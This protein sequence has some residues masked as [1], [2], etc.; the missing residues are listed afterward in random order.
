MGDELDEFL[1]CVQILPT[2]AADDIR[3][4]F[5]KYF[6][7]TD[8]D[9]FRDRVS[10]LVRFPDGEYQRGYMWECLSSFTESDWGRCW[11]ILRES[12]TLYV[13][14]DSHSAYHIQRPNYWRFGRSDVLEC[15]PACLRQGLNLLPDDLYLVDRTFSWSVVRTHEPWEEGGSIVLA[16]PNN[17]RKAV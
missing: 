11:A 12:A 6:L 13:L 15:T 8:S 1:G 3:V 16:H 5:Q 4:K 17:F 7:D 14:W 2:P 9:C 10:E